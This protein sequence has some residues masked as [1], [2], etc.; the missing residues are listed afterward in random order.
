LFHLYR[1]SIRRYFVIRQAILELLYII[2]V[3][4]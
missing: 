4:L 1:L 3:K 2:G